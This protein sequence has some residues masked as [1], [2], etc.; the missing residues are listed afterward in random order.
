MLFLFL[1]SVA[2][3]QDG[4]NNGQCQDPWV[5]SGASC[6]KIE[7]TP[8]TRTAA[9]DACAATDESSLVV[10]E[11]A[12]EN[13]RV[14]L[15]AWSTYNV[16]ELWTAATQSGW[17]T[18]DH[19]NGDA[20]VY[21]TYETEG[22]FENWCCGG[23]EAAGWATTATG[24]GGVLTTV[25]MVDDGNG[26]TIPTQDRTWQMITT[27]DSDLRPYACEIQL[28]A[29]Y[30]QLNYMRSDWERTVKGTTATE[31]CPSGHS[32]THDRECSMSVVF[33][34]PETT[35][36]FA[37]V[38]AAGWSDDSEND[39][40][41]WSSTSFAQGDHHAFIQDSSNTKGFDLTDQSTTDYPY[42]YIEFD[43]VR[44]NGFEGTLCLEV[45]GTSIGCLTFDND[46]SQT[47]TQS[48]GRIEFGASATFEVTWTSAQTAGGAS[49]EVQVS[50]IYLEAYSRT[51]MSRDCYRMNSF[52]ESS[53]NPWFQEW[54]SG[55]RSNS[56][57]LT[58]QF[59]I[60]RE[61]YDVQIEFVGQHKPETVGYT[62]A[63]ADDSLWGSDHVA[64]G[65]SKCGAEIW[66]ADIPWTD[67]AG[68]FTSVEDFENGVA[69]VDNDGG[70]NYVFTAVLNIT[71]TERMVAYSEITTRTWELTRTATWRYPFALKWKR[72]VHVDTTLDV[73]V[74][75]DGQTIC[76]LRHVAA[77]ISFI[78]TE[79]NP[80]AGP[81]GSYGTVVMGIKTLVAYPYMFVSGNQTDDP[82][83]DQISGS[84][85]TDYTS[86]YA[87]WDPP[88]VTATPDADEDGDAQ[89]VDT[90]MQFQWED[91][92][93]CT[94]D[95]N[96]AVEDSTSLEC[97]Q[98]WSL[99]LTPTSGSCYVSGTYLIQ[100]SARCMYNKPVCVFLVGDDNLYQNGVETS[101][102]V[103][104][105]KMCPELVQ[106]VDLSGYLCSTGRAQDG[107]DYDSECDTDA[108]YVQGE[109]THFVTEVDSSLAAIHKTEIIE[110]WASQD[111]STWNTAPAHLLP[112]YDSTYDANVLIWQEGDAL[113]FSNAFNPGDDGPAISDASRETITD[114]SNSDVGAGFASTKAGFQVNLNP[115]IFPAP[116]DRSTDIQFTVI[117]R[118]TYVGFNDFERD[119][120]VLSNADRF[121][122]SGDF[123]W[124]AGVLSTDF[125]GSLEDFCKHYDDAVEYC[126]DTCAPWVA[127]GGGFGGPR[128][129]LQTVIG[130][131]DDTMQLTTIVRMN[132]Q[133][134]EINGHVDVNTNTVRFTMKMEVNDDH[135]G[136]FDSNRPLYYSRLQ[137]KLGH[138]ASAMEG[139]FSVNRMTRIVRGDADALQISIDIARVSGVTESAFYP[140]SIASKLE[141]MIQTGQIYNDDFFHGSEIYSMQYEAV[142][143]DPD[144]VHFGEV[145]PIDE[146]DFSPNSVASFGVLIAMLM[147]VLLW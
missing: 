2:F 21:V 61:L 108:T 85:L 136:L 7:T 91:T 14:A 98:N 58:I 38:D 9:W 72:N 55:F 67:L 121:G 41:G 100:F 59:S 16:E 99:E 18:I 102:T 32:G 10:L 146:V 116:H 118:V 77:I 65:G 1:L 131:G 52:N 135:L 106:D 113:P 123:S 22:Y 69:T 29:C 92:A 35:T 138:L 53:S 42:V 17:E 64:A 50:N 142:D 117:L 111:Y 115:Y 94:H 75:V 125:D 127:N 103:K 34:E 3:A 86:R 130:D 33:G 4:S 114:V 24:K 43:A 147:T 63:T 82:P 39:G 5:W 70:D 128:R 133:K 74:C 54:R 48:V 56:D 83:N 45:E 19:E 139:Q 79:V 95:T 25:T 26:G 132:P 109:T 11:T 137:Y 66:R 20:I 51:D 71:A 36:C 13:E 90:D 46:D 124:C 76:T 88:L 47:F 120:G 27:G 104:S 30:T 23:R 141:M 6:Y 105:T 97:E 112:R 68:V 81:T 15:L 126:P 144:R 110:I 145:S 140:S 57:D 37:I 28:E 134:A 49:A 62:D 12:D 143:E 73:F 60:P 31:D 122:G 40:F 8:A 101:L 129:R 44:A 93:S 84:A 87:Q 119:T 107:L 78:Q 96:G 89:T 80:I